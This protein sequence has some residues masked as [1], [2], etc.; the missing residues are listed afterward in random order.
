MDHEVNTGLFVSAELQWKPLVTLP[1]AMPNCMFLHIGTEATSTPLG[2]LLDKQDWFGISV[3][4]EPPPQHLYEKIL[5]VPL[6]PTRDEHDEEF[7]KLTTKKGGRVPKPKY[8]KLAYVKVLFKQY[9]P[10]L[11]SDND[12]DHEGHLDH[13]GNNDESPQQQTSAGQ[14]STPVART[15]KGPHAEDAPPELTPAA[16]GYG[17]LGV[18]RGTPVRRRLRALRNA[19]AAALAR[20]DQDGGLVFTWPGL[21]FHPVLLFITSYLRGLFTRL[22]LLT[23]EGI[24]SWEVYV[25]G[26]GFKRDQLESSGKGGGA[27]LTS[28]FDCSLRHAHLDDV[29]LWTLTSQSELKEARGERGSKVKGYDDLWRT[30]AGKL[31]SLV[32]ELGTEVT[33]QVGAKRRRPVRKRTAAERPKP[34]PKPKAKSQGKSPTKP[35][36]PSAAGQAAAGQVAAAGQESPAA[37]SRRAQQAPGAGA[38]DGIDGKDGKDGTRG[39]SQGTP[40]KPRRPLLQ[41]SRSMPWLSC[42]LGAA[43]GTSYAGFPDRQ[44][45]T[46]Q[47]PELAHAL[48]CSDKHPRRWH[49]R[50]LAGEKSLPLLP[51]LQ[52]GNQEVASVHAGSN[53]LAKPIV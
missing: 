31:N 12:D 8:F 1:K 9:D 45:F 11:D 49:R 50:R 27:E 22:H 21:P 35:K 52:Q 16:L 7:K 36:S 28:F 51:G 18:T 17:L 4:P 53:G 44:S 2:D 24:R 37:P 15:S 25:L 40:S 23:P 30:Y 29:L 33:A 32:N 42:S 41:M 39:G 26:I 19:L 14:A 47:W 48:D 43:P 3:C 5:Q 38:G 6:D 46:E 20:L 13:E 10:A 34:K